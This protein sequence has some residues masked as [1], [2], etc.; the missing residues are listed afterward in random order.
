LILSLDEH[1][2]RRL[3][4]A[5]VGREPDPG[6][7]WSGLEESALAETGSLFGRAC[8][9]AL[10]RWVAVDAVPSP[11]SFLRDDGAGALAQ[12]LR[13]QAA[14]CDRVLIC[15]GRFHGQ[16]EALNFRILFAPNEGLRKAMETAP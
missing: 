2:G 15:R 6:S 10:R 9:N 4:G 8:A 7:G 11:P 16:G 3:A 5:V 1:D 13:T 12:A 14:S